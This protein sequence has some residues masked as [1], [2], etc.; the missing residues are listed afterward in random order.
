MLSK[1]ISVL[2]VLTLLASLVLACANNEE[3]S[4]EETT[5]EETATEETATEESSA[6]IDIWAKYDSPIELSTVAPLNPED[7]YPE[8][9]DVYD[10][11]W[12]RKASE[13]LGIKIRYNWVVDK[14]QEQAKIATMLASGDMPDFFR[15]DPPT[16][17]KLAEA[18]ALMDLTDIYPKYRS[19]E[20]KTQDEAF[21]EGFQ[22]AFVNGRQYGVAQLGWGKIAL[23]QIL[24]I[25][26]DWLAKS[27]LQVPKTVE[28]LE[29]LALKF[30]EQN[31][32]SYGIAVDKDLTT[33][34]NSMIGLANAHHS[35]PN[36]WIEKDGA[37]AFGS[38]QPEMKQMLSTAQSWYNQGIISKEFSVKDQAAVV[39]D[40]IGS[41]VGIMFGV[42]WMGWWPLGDLVKIDPNAEWQAV[43]IPSFDG[44]DVFIQGD[45]DV[46]FYT[47]VNK[48]AKNPEAVMKLM[49]WYLKQIQ[50]GAYE[51]APLKGTKD[52]TFPV[53]VAQPKRDYDTSVAITNAIEQ[54]DISKLSPADLFTYNQMLPW[55]ESKNVE[56]YGRYKQMG[57]DGSYKVIRQYLDSNRLIITELQG[58]T[59]EGYSKTKATLDKLQLEAFTKIIMGDPVDTTFDEFVK[60]WNALGGQAATDEVNSIYGN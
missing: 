44:K 5:S 35:Y 32:G 26:S 10:N 57:P 43:E 15:V 53:Y 4:T 27:G 25:R 33:H 14:S 9:D 54:N 22:S 40:I 38:T 16:F 52:T 28:E 31:P 55:M 56:G 60:S 48:N 19:D 46:P 30:M 21:P 59:P 51:E 1:L 2:L 58:A 18:G 24:W 12:L 36:I 42:Q 34:V 6:P 41:K 29:A 49:N 47:V 45:W 50:T 13:E 11:A 8:G 17:R 3:T 23:P 7:T 37:I 20:V 39:Q